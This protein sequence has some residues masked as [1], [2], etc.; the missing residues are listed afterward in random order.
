MNFPR[1][2]AVGFLAGTINCATLFALPTPATAETVPPPA[3]AQA[4]SHDFDFN[5]GVWRTHIKRVLEPLSGSDKSVELNGT[6]TVRNVWD[7]RAQIE[8][9]E[10]DGPQTRL[11]GTTLFLYN[12]TAHQWS[13]TF[14]SSKTGILE[15]PLIG[16]F[17]NGRGELFCQDTVDGR[18]VLVRGV[19]SDIAA[20]SHHF[21]ISYSDDGGKSWVPAFIAN[22]TR[23]KS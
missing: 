3:A 15:L 19:W 2:F 11:E 18:S 8:K 9:I 4:I 16:A 5:V 10:A 17:Q 12:P 6:V 20:D 14:A 21:E 23:I 7:G 13:Q 1:R 22:L